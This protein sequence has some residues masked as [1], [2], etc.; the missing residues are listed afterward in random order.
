VATEVLRPKVHGTLALEAALDGRTLDFVVLF[1]S[2]AA[3]VGDFGL[4]DYCAANAFLDAYAQASTSR[5]VMAVD[6]GPWQDVGMAVDAELPD[7]LALARRQDVAER[8]MPPARALEALDRIMRFRPGP[9]VVVSPVKLDVLLA[10]AFTLSHDDDRLV[11]LP[12]AAT[13]ARPEIA[14]SYVP[15]RGGTQRRLCG[16]WQEL[17]GID[18]VGVDDNFFDLGGSSLIAIQLV[19]TINRTL[20]SNLTVTQVYEALTVAR[21]S[22]LIDGV[23]DTSTAPALPPDDL[24]N[25]V[26]LRRQ[27]QQARMLKGRARRR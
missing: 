20:G 17:L 1:G 10:N 27:H 24:K 4:V 25:R 26:S 2:N 7:M 5:R 16:A 6:W 21:L 22:L 19:A 13:H 15:P 18:R 14:T 9:Q 23:E 8:G 3:N 11:N 12:G